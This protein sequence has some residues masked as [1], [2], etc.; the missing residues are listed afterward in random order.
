MSDTMVNRSEVSS[1]QGHVNNVKGNDFSQN[2]EKKSPS[3]TQFL[4]VGIGQC[5]ASIAVE[6]KKKFGPTA[7]VVAI[8]SSQRDLDVL[9]DDLVPKQ[10]RIKFGATDGTGKNR[11]LSQQMIR[12]HKVVGDGKELDIVGHFMYNYLEFLFNGM[13]PVTVIVIASTGGGTGSGSGV[14]FTT[15]LTQAIQK[16]STVNIRGKEIEVNDSN[17]PDVLGIFVT[18]S[19]NDNTEG[20]KSLQNTIECGTE[21]QK[22]IEARLATF[23]IV[24]NELPPNLSHLSKI[25]TIEYVNNR[26]SDS[27]VRFLGTYGKSKYKCIDSQDK[28]TA[29]QTP[30]IFAL[31]TLSDDHQTPGSFQFLLPKR[32]RVRQIV[33]EI[34][35]RLNDSQD[36]VNADYI[37]DTVLSRLDITVDDK[38]IGFFSDDEDST[39]SSQIS[40]RNLVKQAFIGLFGCTEAYALFEPF[41][42]K[43]E[44]MMRAGEEKSDI[45]TTAGH[46]FDNVKE[47]KTTIVNEYS[48][49]TVD[50]NDIDSLLDEI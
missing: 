37:I 10:F 36:G 34:P 4:L 43:L 35:E 22:F 42:Q 46:S 14:Y 44:H 8:N 2:N 17:R 24:T 9:P 19:Y 23:G 26:V 33:A 28:R 11:T 29:M 32:Q 16:L 25:Q 38:N 15:K 18:P 40:D 30:G 6:T 47:T 27:L 39:T 5:G 7:K 31:F 12:S 48:R 41:K 13:N 21:I 49:K 20:V 50:D 3:V 1:Q 45:Q